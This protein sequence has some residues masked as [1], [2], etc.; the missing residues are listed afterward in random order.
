M[1]LV[2][3]NQEPQTQ[4][5][6]PTVQESLAKLPPLPKAERA[7]AIK[8]AVSNIEKQFE[9]IKVQ[10][11][12]KKI[13]MRV[14]SLQTDLPTLDEYALACGGVPDGRILEIYGPESSGKTTLS[15][16]IIAAAQAAGGD[17]AFIDAEHALDPNYAKK[18]GVDVDN[19]YICQPD[20][21]E[22]ALEVLIQ[23]V[24]T[25]SFRIIVVDSVSALVPKAELDGEMGDVHMGL[26]ARMMGQAMRKLVGLCNQTGTT[27]IFINQV[28]EKLG[29]MFGN[30]ETTTGGRA[31]KFYASVR[32]EVRRVANSKGGEIKSGD[33]HIGH[34]MRVKIVKNK[35]GPPFRE[36]ELALLYD[37]GF[38]RQDNWLDYAMS[39]GVVT[40]SGAWYSLGDQK[41][42]KEGLTHGSN[43]DTLK[44]A[45]LAERDNRLAAAAA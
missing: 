41:Y 39:L 18:L 43:F 17:A 42:H 45:A 15:L 37:S 21:G 40:K 38:D 26:Q 11:L 27:V 31:L 44:L 29:V 5:A 12:G 33:I 30:P 20:Y 25:R 23:L 1:S 4:A 13:G 28:R 6:P 22:Q 3:K 8:A 24:K 35:V 16:H 32:A 7:A 2:V 36:T 19:L 34:R 9:G 10:K 14:A